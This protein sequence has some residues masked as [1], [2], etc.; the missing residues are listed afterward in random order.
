M[1]KSRPEVLKD[2]CTAILISSAVTG[3]IFNNIQ[4]QSFWLQFIVCIFLYSVCLIIANRFIKDILERKTISYILIIN[5]ITTIIL[6]ITS[7]I[8]KKYFAFW[9]KFHILFLFCFII[10]LII[11]VLLINKL[12]KAKIK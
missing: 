7:L 4:D 5:S 11:T 9:S 6:L 2:A 1:K 3:I 10:D 8:K 12:K